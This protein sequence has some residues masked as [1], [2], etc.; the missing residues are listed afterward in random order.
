MNPWLIL[1]AMAT[2]LPASR[3]RPPWYFTSWGAFALVLGGGV[4]ILVGFLG[5]GVI[6]SFFRLQRGELDLSRF[7]A[8]QTKTA[9]A[10][11]SVNQR[12]DRSRIETADDPSLGPSDALVT[13]VEFGDFECPFT[14]RSFPIVKDLLAKYGSRIRFIFRDFPNSSIHPNAL[15]A[16]IAAE[17][18]QEQGKFW[19]FHDLL[20]L[21][22]DRLSGQAMIELGSQAGL[23][24]TAFQSC[25][26]GKKPQAEIE[27]DYNAGLTGGVQGTPTWFVNGFRIQGVIPKDVFIKVIDR[28]LAGKL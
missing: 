11:S 15:P 20:F 7:A 3:I 13:I 10:V 19:Q 2:Q 16:A 25:I 21:N 28:G 24:P 18:A 14:L 23:E 22:Q 27:E 4:L 5:Y 9:G 1:K 26:A 6:N 12:V 8:Q 17:C